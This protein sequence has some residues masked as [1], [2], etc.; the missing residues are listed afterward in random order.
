MI[1]SARSARFISNTAAEIAAEMLPA[2]RVE[3][4][5]C[6]SLIAPYGVLE[7]L[8]FACF[9]RGIS[10]CQNAAAL[11]RSV[12]PRGGTLSRKKGRLHPLR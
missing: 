10:F 6:A 7:V 8:E 12:S 4:A 3:T 11:A 9:F 5:Q 2:F 1:N